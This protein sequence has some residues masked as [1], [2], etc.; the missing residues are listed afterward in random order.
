MPDKTGKCI[1]L[2]LRLEHMNKVSTEL[3]DSLGV[4]NITDNN[5][6]WIS[7]SMGATEKVCFQIQVYQKEKGCTQINIPM[8]CLPQ[9]FKK[10]IE[11]Q[12]TCQ[13]RPN[14]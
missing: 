12:K 8:K 1:S 9:Y 2:D 5:V 11:V 3:I 4:P 10:L 13:S 6:S 14:Q 7:K